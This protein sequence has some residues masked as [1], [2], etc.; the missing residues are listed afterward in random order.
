MLSLNVL[1]SGLFHF[2][3]FWHSSTIYLFPVTV[4]RRIL[5]RSGTVS[6]SRCRHAA[7][8]NHVRREW[9]PTKVDFQRRSIHSI[10]QPH[11]SGQFKH[12]CSLH[13]NS[14]VIHSRHT[15]NP[16][17]THKIMYPI[18]PECFME[19]VKLV[20]EST[21]AFHSGQIFF[22]CNQKFAY[23]TES[24]DMCKHIIPGSSF[25][26][27]RT[28]LWMLLRGSN[29][30]GGN[31]YVQPCHF[32]QHLDLLSRF[33]DLINIFVLIIIITI[34]SW[35]R[36]IFQWKHIKN[37]DKLNCSQVLSCMYTVQVNQRCC[38]NTIQKLRYVQRTR[39]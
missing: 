14:I 33:F 36:A 29:E 32:W 9:L 28:G 35:R 1:H 37:M 30:R 20:E 34:R 27:A 24:A 10:L 39:I 22:H 23:F 11:N 21:S 16:T 2:S 26:D 6:T 25:V 7:L 5:S 8:F 13:N 15:N 17:I 12:F 31:F 4:Q 19:Q 38:K 18:M 3:K